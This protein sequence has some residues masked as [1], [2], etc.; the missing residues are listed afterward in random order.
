MLP[1]LVF[2]M[3]VSLDPKPDTNL[4]ST[5]VCSLSLYSSIIRD[6]SL[7]RFGDGIYYTSF[8][9]GASTLTYEK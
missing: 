2:P 5:V 1:G 6:K 8:L 7:F 4:L 9:T 3:L